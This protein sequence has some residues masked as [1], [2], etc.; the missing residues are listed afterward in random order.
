MFRPLILDFTS[1]ITFSAETLGC[2]TRF[3]S[4]VP[5][6]FLQDDDIPGMTASAVQQL[7]RLPVSPA[8]R[9]TF[10]SGHSFLFLLSRL[11]YSVI[12]ACPGLLARQPPTLNLDNAR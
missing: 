11:S 1:G 5:G 7:C 6:G 12:V 9:M 2:E 10:F 8:I 4:P 3:A